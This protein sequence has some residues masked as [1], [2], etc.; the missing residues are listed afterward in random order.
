MTDNTTSTTELWETVREG[1][2]HDN[3][4]DDWCYTCHEP[5]E[6]CDATPALA[7]LDSLRTRMEQLEQERDEARAFCRYE[8]EPGHLFM[9]P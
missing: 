2:P 4:S 8:I 7:A 5:V 6:E 3:T 9:C 1:L